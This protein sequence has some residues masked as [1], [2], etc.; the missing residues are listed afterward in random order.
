MKPQKVFVLMLACIA[1][2]GVAALSAPDSVEH[3]PGLVAGIGDAQ[4]ERVTRNVLD[5]FLGKVAE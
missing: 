3:H 5:R 1:L 4:T 2:A